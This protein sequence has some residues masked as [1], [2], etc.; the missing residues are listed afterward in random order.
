MRLID[1][2]FNEPEKNILFDE[3]LLYL[4][5][6]SPSE[7]EILRL[8]ESPALFVV[9]GRTGKPQ[10]DVHLDRS[11]ADGVAVLRRFS[12]GGT[13]LQGPG[14]LNY[15]LVLS[16]DAHPQI[17][18]LRRSYQYIIGKVLEALKLLS[19]DGVFM[20]ISDMALRATHRKFS[21]NAQKR[22][23]K[24]ILHHGTI[25]C[26]FD[27][28]LIERYLKFPKDVPEYRR[29]RSHI[30][31]VDNLGKEVSAIKAALSGAWHTA[32]AAAGLLPEEADCLKQFL[33]E[34]NVRLDVKKLL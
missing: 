21:G 2:S 31:F 20:P 34:K 24:Y 1:V 3:V 26:N 13:V 4:A 33:R 11:L 29:G 12:G 7:R 10:D 28:G 5:E 15:S 6:Q 19:V 23:R 9:L 17:N 25:L 30:D 8:W 22:G 18:D 27:L 16:K 32:S 14:C